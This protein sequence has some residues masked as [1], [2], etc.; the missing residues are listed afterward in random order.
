M[1]KTI[2]ILAAESD[3]DPTTR[4]FADA[5]RQSGFCGDLEQQLAS[6]L[7]LATDNSIF[8]I[9]P[10]LIVLPK[11]ESDVILL[12]K[13]MA[14]AEFQSVVVTP[15]GGGTGTNGQ[16]LNH[17]V[18]VDFSRY[19]TNILEINVD[20]GWARVESGV[21]L[22]QLN[23]TLKP[24]GYFFS[25]AVSTSSRATIG[26]MMSNDS[27][28]KGSMVYGKTSD[29]VLGLNLILSDGSLLKTKP[30]IDRDELSTLK[31]RNDRVG[32]ILTCIDEVL[33]DH[34]DEIER[35]FP[36][37]NRFMSGYNLLHLRDENQNLRLNYLISGS[38]GTLGLCSEIKVNLTPIPK[39]SRMVAIM[40]RDFDSA[41]RCAKSLAE[42]RPEAVETI[43]DKIMS[44]A[45][46]DAVWQK[47]AHLMDRK[48][49][50]E[51]VM[52]VNFVEYVGDDKDR[53]DQDINRLVEDLENDRFKGV[54]G[55]I[56]ADDPSD[57]A[58][59]WELRKKG[60][61]L[62]GAVKGDKKPVAFVEDTA[63][64]PENLADFIVE[65][66]ALLESH[67]LDYG[68]FGHVDAGCL[69]VR[70]ALDLTL[71]EDQK[72]VKTISDQV[73]DLVLKYG[74][75]MWGEHGRGIRSEYS[76][77]FFGPILHQ[78]LRKIKQAFDPKNQFNPG[79]MV[80]PLGM[81]DL[82]YKI[83]NTTLRG[84]LDANIEKSVRQSWPSAMN[85]NGN[86]ACHTVAPDDV[87]CP[88]SKVTRDR[89]H[90]PKGR[91]GLLRE[92][93]RRCQEEGIDVNGRSSFSFSSFTEKVKSVFQKRSRTEDFH[94][95]VYD[96][97]MGCLS[98]KACATQ[99]PIKVDIPS[100]KS[101]FL[102][103]YHQRYF[104][105]IK[106]HLVA[107]VEKIAPLLSRTA[108]LVNAVQ[109]FAPAK[110]ISQKVGMVDAPDMS[111]P[112]LS[113]AL[114][115]RNMAPFDLRKM[116]GLDKTIKQR[117]VVIVQDAFTS[118]YDA[119]VVTAVIDVLTRLQFRVYVAP[120]MPNGKPMHIKGFMEG[121]TRVAQAN[122][123][124]LQSVADTE[125]PLVGIEP[126]MA[127]T[128]REE[129][130]DVLGKTS[131]VDVKLL[132]EWLAPTLRCRENLSSAVLSQNHKNKVYSLFGHCTEKTSAAASQREW[133]D[134]FSQLGLHLELVATGCCGMAGTYGHETQ[135]VDESKALFN[136]SW[137]PKLEKATEQEHVVLATGFS[138]RCQTK[139]YGG[140][141]PLHPMEVLLE[142]MSP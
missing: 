89:I 108:P 68:M 102:N 137:K 76:P 110:W 65:F 58:G 81:E 79:K 48:P 8:Q 92:W 77:H 40:Y 128:Y 36:K 49:D 53:V 109:N 127:L 63:V 17:G 139:R 61:G 84:Q 7:A 86:G 57:I 34:S 72:L 37:M 42:T 52:A 26:G 9:L 133:K 119:S 55:Y 75:V 20:E 1:S 107:G 103:V 11:D 99:C 60:V 91:A 104:H 80:S 74:G 41:L 19:M 115:T 131:R 83:E 67:G 142:A 135:H 111:S 16:S 114:A 30:L 69:H 50:Q 39:H 22:D 45:R 28:G 141:K 96:A 98:C 124:F 87:M 27:S 136:M 14:K 32:A 43:D 85:C 15:R 122:F 70:P 4:R 132:Q 118:Y 100:M 116:S 78:Q 5:L 130:P 134:I 44:M 33:S 24:L 106:D 112:T 140:F 62:L 73:A 35:V 47:V 93:L 90:S 94:H 121:F 2:P 105:P 18:V 64:P 95:Q 29:H 97:M 31:A 13:I 59:L 113:Q 56:Q 54:V 71:L 23:R 3:I 126:S 21:V 12:G 123:D 25:P 101:R 129:Y 82:T 46:E 51:A 10:D 117:S 120:F 66:R 138:C 88:S 6:R 125:I 38:E